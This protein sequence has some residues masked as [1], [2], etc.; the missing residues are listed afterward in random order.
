MHILS[1]RKYG[2][3]GCEECGYEIDE[4]GIETDNIICKGCYP[5]YFVFYTN[6]YHIL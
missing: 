4:N 3:P 2:G 5:N 1:I 6:D